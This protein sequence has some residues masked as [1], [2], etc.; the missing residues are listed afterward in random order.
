VVVV[1]ALDPG[2]PE[3]AGVAQRL[4]A[5][6]ADEG[7]AAVLVSGSPATTGESGARVVAAGAGAPR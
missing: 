4:S 6:L 7:V 1:A 3:L 5:A 2:D